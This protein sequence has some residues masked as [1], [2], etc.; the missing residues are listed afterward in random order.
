[1]VY[2]VR[3]M[4][5]VNKINTSMYYILVY[6]TTNEKYELSPFIKPGKGDKYNGNQLL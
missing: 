1:M 5:T 4:R 3:L 6:F 2:N